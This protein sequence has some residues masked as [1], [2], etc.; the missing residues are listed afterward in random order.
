MSDQGDPVTYLMD[1]VNNKLVREE[2]R[3]KGLENGASAAVEAHANIFVAKVPIFLSCD[4][5]N[6]CVHESE[7][8]FYMLV[9]SLE[10]V[11]SNT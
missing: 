3:G 11:N 1:S 5:W 9:C 10:Q 2:E 7:S 6:I 4:I 8:L